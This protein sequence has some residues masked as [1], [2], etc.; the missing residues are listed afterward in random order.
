MEAAWLIGPFAVCGTALVLFAAGL[1]VPLTGLLTALKGS[2]LSAIVAAAA[3][4][5]TK[6]CACACGC[7]LLLLLHV[8]ATL[9]GG[10]ASS[11]RPQPH[12][13]GSWAHVGQP[14]LVGTVALG[15][16]NL[17]VPYASA[18][19]SVLD[20]RSLRGMALA[21]LAGLAAVFLLNIGTRARVL[22][23]RYS[24]CR[25]PAVWCFT[26]LA[27]V[28]R[29]E[30]ALAEQRGEIAT[31]PLLR[32]I[33]RDFPHFAAVAMLVDL[34]LVLSLSASFLIVGSGARDALDGLAAAW[35]RSRAPLASATSVVIRRWSRGCVSE[36]VFLYALFYGSM[37]GLALAQPRGF[38]VVMEAITSLS[39]N[40]QNGVFI[41]A[42]GLAAYPPAA[43]AWPLP[44]VLLRLR[45]PTVC[46]F[47]LASTF[48]ILRSLLSLLSP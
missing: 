35:A 36:R 42:L 19:L 9:S 12:E 32:V 1:V 41:T 43:R 46:F 48:S 21:C 30:L 6:V 29:E 8:P 13:W 38:L 31:V 5:A 45:W 34:F 44:R 15:G 24:T 20:A 17:L 2:L 4:V 28:P 37:S 47:L 18:R 16:A 7:S 11:G 40:L 33:R 22:P 39:L 26:L 14:L 3:Y 25:P 23:A 27:V 10:Q